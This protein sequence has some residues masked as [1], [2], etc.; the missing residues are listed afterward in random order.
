MSSLDHDVKFLC[1]THYGR[2]VTGVDRVCLKGNLGEDYLQ[3]NSN[4]ILDEMRLRSRQYKAAFV[5]LRNQNWDPDVI[6]SH[7]G[8][9]CGVYSRYVWPNA[10]HIVYSEWW[11][12]LDADIFT[13][14]N[15][16]EWLDVSPTLKSKLW[17]RNQL[18][19][20]ELLDADEI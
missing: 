10:K 13:S 2:W 15:K 8:W 5:R 6:I 3:N 7:N 20:L 17:E 4:S 9:G 14:A 12:K 16:S 1:Q 19:G 18:V 11:Y